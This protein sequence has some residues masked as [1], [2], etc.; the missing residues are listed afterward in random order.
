MRGPTVHIGYH[1]TGTTYLQNYVYPYLTGLEYVDRRASE[2]YF[3]PLLNKDS[4]SIPET[5]LPDGLYSFEGLVG[6]LFDYSGE[7]E[8]IAAA[9]KNIGFTRIIITIREP[10][11]LI[12]SS[13]RQWIQQGASGSIEQFLSK[14]FQMEYLDYARTIGTYHRLFGSES[15]LVLFNEELKKNPDK[16]F[17][18]ISEFLDAPPL[19]KTR[20]RKSGSNISLSNAS[21]RIL[22]RLNA[23]SDMTARIGL[24]SAKKR[25][26]LQKYLDPYLISYFSSRSSFLSPEMKVKLGGLLRPSLEETQR[27]TGLPLE[28]YGYL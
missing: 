10:L 7:M 13:Y 19:E 15:V 5:P 2:K 23:W 26:I 14:V 16:V 28:K 3:S 18:Q 11:S 12:D 8:R 17:E 9:L 20:R 25:L 27:L 22:S 1:K 6:A 21:I 4:H 24:D